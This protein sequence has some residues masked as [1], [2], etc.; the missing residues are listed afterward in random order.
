MPR[1]SFILIP[2][3]TVTD[4]N[5]NCV[6][7]SGVELFACEWFTN[8][9]DDLLFTGDCCRPRSVVKIPLI[10]MS[11]W[12]QYGVLDSASRFA[13]ESVCSAQDDRTVR[14]P[15]PSV[16]AAGPRGERRQPVWIHVALASEHQTEA[17]EIEIDDGRSE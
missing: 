13:S 10:G 2:T 1:A 15:A 3:V 7:P 14:I 6:I 17:I 4:T 16:S 5:K 12:S 8:S 11:M 9:W